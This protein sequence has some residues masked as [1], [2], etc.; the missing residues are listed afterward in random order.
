MTNI[1][2]PEKTFPAFLALGKLAA[3]LGAALHREGA[4]QDQNL[5]LQ[6]A[7]CCRCHESVDGALSPVKP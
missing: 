6:G 7:E 2:F 1:S 3:M 5:S 4:E